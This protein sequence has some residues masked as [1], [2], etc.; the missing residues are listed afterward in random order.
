MVLEDPPV[1]STE[2][3]YFE[4]SF[5]YQDTYKIMHEYMSSAQDEC[6]ETYYLRHCL[7][8]Q[9]YMAS[10][11]DGLANYAQ[12]YHEN[13]TGKPVQLFFL[14]ESIN[15]MFLYSPMYDFA[16][17]EHFYDYSWHSGISH[18]DLMRAIDIPTVF[19]HVEEMY[20][21]DGVLMAASSNAQAEKA[22]ALIGDCSFLPL[23]GN[24]DIHRF[25]PDAFVD[26]IN[27]FK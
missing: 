26:A 19:L 10:S 1:F 3:D 24:H 5:A 17:G 11:M 18:E 14:P 20:S 22:A 27:L 6:W 12:Q 13:N 9:L 15:F 23:T 7:W 4:K 8:G 2:R 25:N 21:E 16:F